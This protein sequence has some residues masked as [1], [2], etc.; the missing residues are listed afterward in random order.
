MPA[1]AQTPCSAR[2]SHSQWMSPAKVQ[3]TEDAAYSSI[4]TSST[5][6][7]PSASDSVPCHNT[8]SAKGAM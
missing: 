4:A 1:P 8:I 5:R 3:A 7:R 6:R 2:P